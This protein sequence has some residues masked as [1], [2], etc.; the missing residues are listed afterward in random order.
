MTDFEILLSA[1]TSVT[2]SNWTQH[3]PVHL[4]LGLFDASCLDIPPA[5]LHATM[6]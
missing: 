6:G 3:D 4:K 5:T 1:D 2:Q